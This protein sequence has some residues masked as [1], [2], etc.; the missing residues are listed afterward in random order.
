[1]RHNHAPGAPQDWLAR[2]RGKLALAQQPLPEGGYWEDLCYMAQQAVELALKAIYQEKG[3]HFAFVHDIGHL[4][5]DLENHGLTLPDSIREAE[6]LTVYATQ[7]RYPG[8]YGFITE[9]DYHVVI[10]IA[11]NT[12]DWASQVIFR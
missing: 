2:A 10:A 3:W 11:E 7:M 8:S 1:M 12:V 6:I 5:D 4:L 9:Q